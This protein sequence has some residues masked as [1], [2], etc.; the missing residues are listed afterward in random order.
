[1]PANILAR[2]HRCKGNDSE[3]DQ[4]PFSNRCKCL[5]VSNE[6]KKIPSKVN[7]KSLRSGGILI[8]S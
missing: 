8:A 6:S 2:P 4:S 5:I 3:T 1:M 7:N